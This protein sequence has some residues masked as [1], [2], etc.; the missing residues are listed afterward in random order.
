[1]QHLLVGKAIWAQRSIPHT[2]L[3][4][5]PIHGEP[6]VLQS[7]LF[8]AVLYPFWAV[9][10]EMGIFVW[11]WLTTL[12]A[13][14]LLWKATRA[15][16]ARGPW[17][18]V[19]LLW[20]VMLYRYRSQAR[21]ETLVAVLVAAQLWLLEKR[22][23][24]GVQPG[25][26]DPAW[27]VVPIA[28]LWANVHISYYLGLLL[29][30]FHLAAAL[31][32]SKRARPGQ[33]PNTLFLALLAS[34]AVSLVN[35]FGWKALAEP[36]RYF[37]VWRHEPIYHVIGELRPVDWSVFAPVMLPAWLGLLVILAIWRW[38][39]RGFDLVE[40]L[41]LAVFVPQALST[42]RFLGYLAVL[43]APFMARNLDEACSALRLPA[44]AAPWA[45]AGAV[46][47][48]LLALALPALRSPEL[49]PGLGFV[50]N[51]F[52]VAACDWIEAHDVRGRGFNT[53][54]F[55]GY[56]LWRFWPEA[57][58]LPFMDAHAAGTRVDRD[59]AAYVTTHEKVWQQLDDAR[60]FDY[61]LMPKRQFSGQHMLDFLDADS[62]TWAMVFVDDAAVLYLRRSGPLAALAARESYRLLP[63]GDAAFQRLGARLGAD[64]LLRAEVRR[65]LQRMTAAS[66]WT[67]GA[68]DVLAELARADGRPDEAARETR[69]AEIAAV[70]RPRPV[71]RI[72]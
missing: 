25:R 71:D 31:F 40:L 45:R 33:S 48:L 70:A 43:V 68:H 13:F 22:R 66:A 7:W 16:G 38:W 36:F 41:V 23:T 69:L 27:G 37:F 10:G 14:G 52:P 11:R 42:Q 6:D 63:G 4:V 46:A 24:E 53:F 50:W 9:G 51:E 28:L 34:A 18:L 59:R 20:C 35:P 72:R 12:V 26:W 1:W 2:Q 64:S 49:R 5:W 61:V 29:T 44:L 62:V 32:P 60:R 8:R 15:A 17:A 57:G 39:R 3:W 21:P 47:G 67:S 56:M 54:G 19:A 55:G 58:R 30:A 65:E